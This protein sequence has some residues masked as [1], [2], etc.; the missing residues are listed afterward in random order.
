MKISSRFYELGNESHIFL[1]A[2]LTLFGKYFFNGSYI[3]KLVYFTGIFNIPNDLNLKRKGKR[4]ILSMLNISKG[5]KRHY[6]YLGSKSSSHTITYEFSILLLHTK[7]KIIKKLN[8]I[9][10]VRQS[11]LSF[12]SQS[13]NQ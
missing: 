7:K 10:L 6:Y 5:S 13:Y 8:K 3:T 11:S 9:K 1:A 12:L 4:N 2:K